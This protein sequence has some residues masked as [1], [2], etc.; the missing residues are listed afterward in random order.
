[1]F[2]KIYFIIRILT[3]FFKYQ[4]HP[5]EQVASKNRP[6][7]LSL[8]IANLSNGGEQQGAALR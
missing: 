3:G 7:D 4:M 6:N 8:L 2:H 5:S 1:M